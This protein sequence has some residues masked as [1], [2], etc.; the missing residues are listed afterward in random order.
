MVLPA[1]QVDCTL[2]HWGHIFL[3]GFK[4][5]HVTRIC[6]EGGPFNGSETL[7]QFFYA[8]LASCEHASITFDLSES[9]S[10]RLSFMTNDI[11]FKHNI[12]AFFGVPVLIN[13]IVDVI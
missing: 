10:L 3:I 13:L 1:S 12:P 5:E 2:I 8:L 11:N 9:R 6:T 7:L 4:G